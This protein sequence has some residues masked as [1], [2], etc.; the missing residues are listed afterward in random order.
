M[1]RV[2]LDVVWESEDFDAAVIPAP[3]SAIG[4]PEATF[5]DGMAHAA[6]TLHLRSHWR[7]Y[8]SSETSL[9]YFI[10]GFPNFGHLRDEMARIET[11]SALPLPGYLTQ[12]EQQAWDG[13]VRPVPQMILEVDAEKPALVEPGIDERAQEYAR[14]LHDTPDGAPEPFGGFSGGAVVVVGRDGEHLIGMI[15]EGGRLFGARRVVASAWDDV[16]TAF[17][18]SAEWRAYIDRTNLRG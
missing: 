11:L 10:L 5:F 3:P 2:E 7:K 18:S 13:L 15:K 8:D 16:V 9:P 6:T 4:A 1:C 14:R 12:L 17:T